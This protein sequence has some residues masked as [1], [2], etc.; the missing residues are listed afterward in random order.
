MKKL[1]MKKTAALMAALMTLTLIVPVVAF[2]AFGDFTANKGTVT[3]TVYVSEHTYLNFI[4]EVS[5]KKLITVYLYD[6][7]GNW[8]YKDGHHARVTAEYAPTK[9]ANGFTYFDFTVDTMAYESYGS[10]KF[11]YADP[12]TAQWVFSGLINRDPNPGTGNIIVIPPT[13]STPSDITVGA[14]GRVPASSLAAALA[15]GTATITITGQAAILPAS[16]LT[17]TGTVTIMNAAGVSYT[18]PLSGIDVN[19]LATELGVTVANLEIRV[20]IN[21][22]SGTAAQAVEAAAAAVGGDVVAPIIDFKVV[23]VGGGKTQ[24]IEK[25]PVY[26]SRTLPL[27]E[28]VSNPNSVT[29]VVYDESTGAVSFVPSTFATVDG[30]TTA[31]LKRNGNSIYTVVKV[32]GKSFGDLNG[33][34]AKADV[35]KL[36]GKFVITG[37]SATTFEPKRNITRAEVAALIVR[38]LGLD[39]TG[40]TSK[41]SD[42]TSGKW[43]S[44]VVAAAVDAG[45]INGYQDGTFKPDAAI[46]RRDLAAMI[47]RAQAFA[48]KATTLTDAQVAQALAGYTDAATLGG[49][50]V[51]VAIAVSTG[52][53][54]GQS[55]TKLAGLANTNRA[56]AATLIARLLKGVNFID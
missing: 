33:H 7:A 56:E 11:S 47:V 8:V 54:K 19:A 37:T 42:V 35:E 15:D 45:I 29:G 31:T 25:F 30:K 2:A 51:N 27:N 23:A 16:A 20:E 46:T 6:A 50:R 24:E 21:P 9:T 38:S 48:G 10:L 36:A 12:A 52:L 22:L 3:G 41:F 43:Y 53:M 34:W 17:S 55:G 1:V 5:G 40:T 13:G 44:G 28:T 14:D 39:A 49:Q 4:P 18:L 26:V 32:N